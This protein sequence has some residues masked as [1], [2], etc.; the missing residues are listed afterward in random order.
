MEIFAPQ[1]LYI[2]YIDDVKNYGVFTNSKIKKGDLVEE[3]ICALLGNYLIYN[4]IYDYIFNNGEI[5]LLPFGFG[6]VYNHSYEPNIEWK[7][8]EN[9]RFI[10]F[11]ALRDINENEELTHNYGE[12][13]WEW[14]EQSKKQRML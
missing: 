3:C 9:K 1:N 8:T 12:H 10:K 14:Y 5:K 2:K 6:S 4:P 11:Y 7:I 13:Y